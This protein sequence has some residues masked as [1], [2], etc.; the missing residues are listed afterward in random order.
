VSVWRTFPFAMLLFLAA[1][2]TV[3]QDLIEASKMDGAGAWHRFWNVTFPLIKSTVL[4]VAIMLSL[5]YFNHID[6]PFVMTG[7]GPLGRTEILAL[8]AYNEAFVFDRMGFGSAVAVLVF[9]VNMLLSLAYMRILRTE[10][11]V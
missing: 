7:G 1:L 2:Q 9:I 11:H 4:V 6:L 8:R 3:P 10:R 5:S